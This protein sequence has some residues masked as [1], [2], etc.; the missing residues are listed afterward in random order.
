[1]KFPPPTQACQH[2]SSLFRSCV[3]SHIV[4]IS[5][6]HF[7]YHV[8]K[9]LSGSRHPGPLTLTI[10]LSLSAC[11]SLCFR[12]TVSVAVVSAGSGHPAVSCSLPLTSVG[13]LCGFLSAT[14]KM[15]GENYICL[16]V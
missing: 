12:C 14:K 1:M 7:A 15:R 4:G 2:V 9:M 8:G 5:L 11:C 10:S 3:S 16:W 6:V 13:F